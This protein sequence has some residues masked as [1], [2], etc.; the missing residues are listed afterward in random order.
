M[1]LFGIVDGTVD[2]NDRPFFT[3]FNIFDAAYSQAE[4][5]TPGQVY[6]VAL[7]SYVAGA[8]FAD[9]YVAGAAESG[10]YVAGSKQGIST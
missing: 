2:E 7:G 5:S 4:P 10:L 9:A 1:R 8:Q 3:P 6:V